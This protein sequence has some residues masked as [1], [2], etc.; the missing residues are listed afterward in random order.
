MAMCPC[1]RKLS[2]VA[3][4]NVYRSK[5]TGPKG[6]DGTIYWLVVSVQ[7]NA[8]HMLGLNRNWEVVSTT[9]YGVRVMEE[10]PLLYRIKN[11][12]QLRLTTMRGE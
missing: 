6:R 3:V 5:A 10:R 12:A 1:H 8:C 9:S 11:V 2:D 7:G 4:G